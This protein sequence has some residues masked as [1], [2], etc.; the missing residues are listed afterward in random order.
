MRDVGPVD[1]SEAYLVSRRFP[2]IQIVC[3]LVACS[4]FVVPMN[5]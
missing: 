1:R 4:P 3:Q 5:A 2:S